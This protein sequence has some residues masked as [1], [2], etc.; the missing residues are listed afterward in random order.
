MCIR[1][2]HVLQ[3]CLL[4]TTAQ[5]VM[6]GCHSSR[7]AEAPDQVYTREAGRTI[8]KRG[9]VCVSIDY[10]Q[11]SPQHGYQ[12]TKAQKRFSEHFYRPAFQDRPHD[13]HWNY[14]EQ[15]TLTYKVEFNQTVF[16]WKTNS[17][18]SLQHF[19]LAWGEFLEYQPN[20]VVVNSLSSRHVTRDELPLFFSQLVIPQ[21]KFLLHK[22]QWSVNEYAY[23]SFYKMVWKPDSIILT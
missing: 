10:R 11:T 23:F 8:T 4:N 22:E 5:L 16:F 2:G 14:S 18:W 1:L 9:Q 20:P 17:W 3:L 19:S 21:A 12:A 13:L 6:W 7:S 15:I